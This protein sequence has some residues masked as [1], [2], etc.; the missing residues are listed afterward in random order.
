MCSPENFAAANKQL[1]PIANNRTEE[2]RCLQ[3]RT[4]MVKYAGENSVDLT[5][6]ADQKHF[7][8]RARAECCS[9]TYTTSEASHNASEFTNHN[10]DSKLATPNKS[11]ELIAEL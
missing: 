1:P 3:E 5:T 9:A 11:P 10:I 2:A 6:H 8:S 7:S 4:W